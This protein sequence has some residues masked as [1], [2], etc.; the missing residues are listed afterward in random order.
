MNYHNILHD[1][2][3]NGEGLRVVLFVSGCN[4]FCKGCQNP[5]TWNKCSGILFDDS[6][7]DEIFTQLSKDYIDGITLT[8]GDPLFPENRETLTSLCKEIKN[9]FPNKTI[10]CYTGYL[11][12][13]VKDLEII[14]Y[15]DVLVDGPYKEELRDITL[16]WVGSSNQR[17]LRLTPGTHQEH[18]GNSCV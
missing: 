17:V 6:A 12:E 11:Y 7:K 2:M 1:N 14:K 13:K 4:H 3:I 18:S 16:P 5:E 9:K 8:G 10:W 15:I